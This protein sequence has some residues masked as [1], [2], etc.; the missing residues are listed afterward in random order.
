MNI[1]LC[2][3]DI[4]E[5]DILEVTN[6]LRSGWITS[7]P[8]GARFEREFAKYKGVEENQVLAVSS[9]TAALHL[10]LLAA[11]IGSDDEVITTAMTFSATV[12]EIVHV[13]A[14]PVL[15]DVENK[16]WNIDPSQ[17]E[18]AI[19]AKTK[20][21]LIVHYA[22]SPCD[23]NAIMDIV[24]KYNLILI[25][26]C[27]HAIESTY[28]GTPLGTFGDFS[29]FSFYASKNLTTAEGGMIIAK[30]TGDLKT[31]KTMSL[32][33]MDRDAWARGK[34]NKF[35]YLVVREG[36]KYN[37]SDV[38]A[39]IGVNQL[40]R[41]EDNLI[42]RES[43]WQRYVNA[44]LDIPVQLPYFHSG[45]KH[46]YH[47]FTMCVPDQRDKLMEHL[48]ANSI[49]SSIHYPPIPSH[50][51]FIEKYGWCSEDYPVATKYGN[52]TITLPLFPG[53]TDEEVDFIIK[54]VKDFF[55]K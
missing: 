55:V 28:E 47:I 13:G 6:C 50:P 27:A 34:D 52:E 30:S 53:L 21:L 32:H 17:I 23:M 42:K 12:H 7:G 29:A 22:G 51:Y 10:A 19:T 54:T 44:F 35:S 41:L 38:H 49:A 18:A 43:V 48:R 37:L 39:A 31:L 25:E 33:G 26:D 9:C 11:G 36:F 24:K 5:D 15:V 8:I 3:A 1:P 46:A 45:I 16:T 4:C 2:R 20:A 40:S 14:R